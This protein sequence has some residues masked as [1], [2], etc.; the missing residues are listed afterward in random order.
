ME[1]EIHRVPDELMPFIIRNSNDSDRVRTAHLAL[2]S[3]ERRDT[4]QWHL[5]AVTGG[6]R[7]E[8]AHLFCRCSRE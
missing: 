3:I 7:R 2:E 8:V 5:D 4:R 1:T 6:S